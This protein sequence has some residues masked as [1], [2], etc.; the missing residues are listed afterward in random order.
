MG[1]R[2]TLGHAM[3]DN[4]KL[5]FGT[6]ETLTAEEQWL[7]TLSAPLSAFNGDHVNA[8]ATGKDDEVLRAGISEVWNVHD[9]ESFEQT[10]RWL[11]EEGQRSSY[12]S[13]WQAVA[14]IDAATQSTPAVLRLIMD[15]WFPAFFQIKAR[16]SLDYRALSAE[17]GRPV[18]ELSQMTVASQSWVHALRKHFNVS[19]PQISDLV[20]WDA[21]R[22]ASLSRW[23]VQLGFIGREEFTSFASALNAQVREAY[24]D[25]SQ[26]SAAYIAAG[27]IWRYSGAREEHLLRTNRM[28][29]NDARSPY[30]S[31]PFR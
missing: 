3:L 11:T 23:A 28:L 22:L 15:A 2:D 1:I 19:P 18:S 21:V 16:K 13:T 5:H 8:L 30:R 31:V 9:R 14:A 25:W 24:A 20:A 7:V 10:A 26:V 6:E 29:L 27:L 12:L 17:S 4:E